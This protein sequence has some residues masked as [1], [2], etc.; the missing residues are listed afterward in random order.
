MERDY[1]RAIPCSP[2]PNR[3]VENPSILP[4]AAWR[5]SKAGFVGIAPRA[6]KRTRG[7]PAGWRSAKA[8]GERWE[9]HARGTE[10][11]RNTGGDRG[12]AARGS[13]CRHQCVQPSGSAPPPGG[14]SGPPQKP[15]GRRADPPRVGSGR[16]GGASEAPAHPHR[17]D[18]LRA[19]V[20][21]RDHEARGPS[22]RTGEPRGTGLLE[23]FRRSQLVRESRSDRVLVGEFRPKSRLAELLRRTEARAARRP[24]GTGRRP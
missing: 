2:S 18:H 1:R 10:T 17:L 5:G 19:Q 21:L 13:M 22:Q 7:T 24:T 15:G 14:R 3:Q 16:V 20:T 8:G 9:E 12:R 11:A 4:D 23:P 6:T